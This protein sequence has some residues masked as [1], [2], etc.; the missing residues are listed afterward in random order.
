MHEILLLLQISLLSHSALSPDFL[1]CPQLEEKFCMQICIN[2][3]NLP[4]LRLTDFVTFITS[5]KYFFPCNMIYSDQGVRS[6]GAIFL[7]TI[8]WLL[9]ISVSHDNR[10]DCTYEPSFCLHSFSVLSPASILLMSLN[11][12]HLLL[13][14]SCTFWN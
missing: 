9:G 2:I 1:F 14:L 4:S 7:P 12:H 10:T 6:L 11:I 5:V 13:A 3:F 8:W